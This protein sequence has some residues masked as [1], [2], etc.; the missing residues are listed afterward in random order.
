[1]VAGVALAQTFAPPTGAPDASV[2]APYEFGYVFGGELD[3]LAKHSARFSGSFGILTSRSQF[4]FATRNGAASGY[5]ATLGGTIVQDRLWFFASGYQN[6]ALLGSRFGTA[7]RAN[8]SDRALSRG[9]DTKVNAQLGDAQNL[10]ASFAT[11]REPGM[12]AMTIAAPTPSSFLS[13]RYTGIVSSNMFFT[14][15][16]SRGTAPQLATP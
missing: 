2:V 1:M 4:P 10:A 5:D 7:P 13:L 8:T 15:S 3:L 12:T 14:A 6:E 16:V 11:G 9:I